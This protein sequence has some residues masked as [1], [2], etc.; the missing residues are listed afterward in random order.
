MSTLKEARI[1]IRPATKQDAG[2]LAKIERR[3]FDTAIY[4]HILLSE[5]EF[6]RMVDRSRAQVIVAET[7]GRV[8]GYASVYYLRARR[9][10]WFYSHAVDSEYRGLGIGTR[11]FHGVEDLAVAN[12]CPCMILEIRGKRELYERYL[13]CGYKVIREIPKFYPDGSAAIRMG[14]LLTAQDLTPP[15][16]ASARKLVV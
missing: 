9:L 14:R 15:V 5:S 8:V 16:H 12:D 6:T 3:C 2:A 10:T 11:L 1:E 7:A 13:R 4:G